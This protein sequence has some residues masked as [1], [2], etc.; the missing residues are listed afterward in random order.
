M[1]DCARVAAKNPAAEPSQS[2][3]LNEIDSVGVASAF[4]TERAAM[5]PWRTPLKYKKLVDALRRNDQYRRA[6]R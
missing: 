3:D 4:D 2:F 5:F 1:I 6:T